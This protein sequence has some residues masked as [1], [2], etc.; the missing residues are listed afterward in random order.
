MRQ[1]FMTLSVFNVAAATKY[2]YLNDKFS[3]DY[4]FAYALIIM[5]LSSW[6]AISSALAAN[7]I[8]K[9][10]DAETFKAI[11]QIPKPSLGSGFYLYSYYA[12]LIFFFAFYD[13][14]Y[15]ASAWAA[16][17]GVEESIKTIAYR[18][19]KFAENKTKS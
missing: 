14:Y 11:V 18:N 3:R 5:I 10:G 6:Q 2:I 9:Y 15:F 16:I 12:C 8:R 4:C 19:W 17:F 7:M 13:H 1:L